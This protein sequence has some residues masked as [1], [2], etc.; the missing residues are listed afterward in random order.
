MGNQTNSTC[1]EGTNVTRETLIDEIADSLCNSV[2][3]ETLLKLYY[4]DNYSW[5]ESLSR[6]DL[7]E[8][9]RHVLGEKVEVEDYL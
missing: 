8:E 6:K 3:Q 7:L 4:D 1:Y 5:L 2:D 9:A